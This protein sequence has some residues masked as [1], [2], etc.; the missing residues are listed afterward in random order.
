M[1]VNQ[2][3]TQLHKQTFLHFGPQAKTLEF[4]VSAYGQM[5]VFS[6]VSLW[7]FRS[8]GHFCLKKKV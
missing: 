1:S 7:E 5:E 8:N 2:D 3:V 4:S 6:S